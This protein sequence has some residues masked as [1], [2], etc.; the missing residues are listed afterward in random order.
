MYDLP[1]PFFL[2]LTALLHSLNKRNLSRIPCNVMRNAL[3]AP[4]S[5]LRPNAVGSSGS[6]NLSPDNHPGCGTTSGE[7][8]QIVFNSLNKAMI[9]KKNLLPYSSYYCIFQSYSM[10]MRVKTLY[11]IIF[12][13]I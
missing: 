11:S 9:R 12:S 5:K 7:P 6:L 13:C 10:S 1:L 4:S 2:T 8:Q 3:G